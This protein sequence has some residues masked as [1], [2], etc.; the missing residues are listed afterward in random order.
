M[1][2]V[3]DETVR[4]FGDEWQRFEQIELSEK[5]RR[6]LFDQYF[7][8]FPF[9]EQSLTWEGFDAGCGSGRWAVLVAARVRKLHLID[10]SAE[11][12]RVARHNLS[13]VTN[14]EFHRQSLNEID[15]PESS[16]DFGYSLGVL[17]HVPDTASAL[18]ACVRLLKPGAPFLVYL[19]YAL[20]TR[21]A[22]F[23]ALWRLSDRFRARIA[24]MPY[25]IRYGTTQVIAAAVYWPLARA[26]ALGST[27]G[28]YVSNWPLAFYRH[29]SFYV[30]RTD[31]LDRFGTRLEKRFSR[32]QV[33]ELMQQAG[34]E[35]IRFSDSAPFWCAVGHKTA[36]PPPSG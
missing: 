14:C 26:A 9:T 12:L 10:A 35:S 6:E 2:N 25:A 4:G 34:L 1:V 30:M 5:E 23:R 16:Q 8:I 7:H 31:A 11:A 13:G 36:P 17:H 32:R 21:P 28:F 20:D 24:G 18:T 15:L 33:L 3:D 22:W 27:L 29:R 19:Y